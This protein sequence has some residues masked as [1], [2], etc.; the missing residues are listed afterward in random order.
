MS[1]VRSS[2]DEYY[3]NPYYQEIRHNLIMHEIK[4]KRKEEQ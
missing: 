4:R 2:Y 3:N 1:I